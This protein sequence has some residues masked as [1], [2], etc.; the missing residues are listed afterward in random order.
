MGIICYE[1][2]FPLIDSFIQLLGIH[3]EEKKNIVAA[4]IE[5][6]QSSSK[7]ANEKTPAIGFEWVEDEGMEGEDEEDD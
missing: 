1:W 7:E 5:K 6:I 4:R 2:V 3:L